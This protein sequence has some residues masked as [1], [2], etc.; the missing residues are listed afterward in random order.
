MG[1]APTIRVAQAQESQHEFIAL[2]S[3]IRANLS[4]L[5]AQQHS[6]PIVSGNFTPLH[7]ICH[8]PLVA[9]IVNRPFHGGG[10][11]RARAH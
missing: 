4:S 2:A 5:G 9:F 3:S 11:F 8:I 7:I 6:I 10:T 1:S